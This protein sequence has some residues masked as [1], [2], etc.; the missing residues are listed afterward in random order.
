MSRQVVTRQREK[1]CDGY[2]SVDPSSNDSLDEMMALHDM[3]WKLFICLPAITE[4]SE[5]RVVH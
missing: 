4:R 5:V 1:Q 2:C 3:K